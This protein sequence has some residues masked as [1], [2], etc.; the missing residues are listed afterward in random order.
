MR[1]AVGRLGLLSLSSVRCGPNGTEFARETGGVSL[2]DACAP[3]MHPGFASR[4]WCAPLLRWAQRVH[5]PKGATRLGIAA[6]HPG[7]TW[8]YTKHA[9]NRKEMVHEERTERGFW[10]WTRQSGGTVRTIEQ[11]R[12]LGKALWLC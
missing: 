11:C 1:E 6:S 12:R 5:L 2:H 7:Q 3:C 10:W 4:R 9:G 8:A